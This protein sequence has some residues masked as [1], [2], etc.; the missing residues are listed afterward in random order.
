MGSI[1][2]P[3]IGAVASSLS[4]TTTWLAERSHQDQIQESNGGDRSTACWL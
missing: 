3:L 1:A 4:E 2:S